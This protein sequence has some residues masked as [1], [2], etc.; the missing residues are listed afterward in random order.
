MSLFDIIVPDVLW[1]SY[2][3]VTIIFFFPLSSFEWDEKNTS[4]RKSV[5]VRWTQSTCVRKHVSK[6]NRKSKS[7]SI[8][9]RWT[10]VPH[11]RRHISVRWRKYPFQDTIFSI[12]TQLMSIV[13]LIGSQSLRY[14][15]KCRTLLNVNYLWLVSY[16]QC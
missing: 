13:I 11:V 15:L 16:E 10:H 7:W 5:R 1:G 4:F 8:W 3:N 2:I 6:T 14:L 9:M 12:S